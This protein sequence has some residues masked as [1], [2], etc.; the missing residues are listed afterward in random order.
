VEIIKDDNNK[1]LKEKICFATSEDENILPNID[2]IGFKVSEI[3]PVLDEI[4][5]SIIGLDTKVNSLA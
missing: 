4:L 2:N 5:T 1:F 3:D